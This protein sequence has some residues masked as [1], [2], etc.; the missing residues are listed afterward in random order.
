MYIPHDV[1]SVIASA[2]ILYIMNN[3]YNFACWPLPSNPIFYRQII[4]S[5]QRG[6]E[7][8]KLYNSIITNSQGYNI[9]ATIISVRERESS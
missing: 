5:Y 9:M 6:E 7:T 8:P 1:V 2:C 3:V 4:A